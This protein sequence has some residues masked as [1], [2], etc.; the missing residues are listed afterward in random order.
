MRYVYLNVHTYMHIQLT[1]IIIV[2]NMI[3]I[4]IVTIIIASIVIIIDKLISSS[5]YV[6]ARTRGSSA[7]ACVWCSRQLSFGAARTNPGDPAT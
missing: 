5:I 3:T 6:F 1:I 4:N 2:M 7:A